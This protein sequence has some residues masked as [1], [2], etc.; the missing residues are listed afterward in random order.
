M[1]KFG[2][3]TYFL[4]HKP[5]DYP[6]TEDHREG[7]T[8]QDCCQ[9]TKHHVLISIEPH[10]VGKNITQKPQQMVDHRF[11]IGKWSVVIGDWIRT[12]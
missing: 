1:M 2:P 10:F 8:R 3:V 12:N 5:A 7:E 9:G 4:A 11:T 6:R